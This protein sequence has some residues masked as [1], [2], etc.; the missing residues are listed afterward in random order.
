[1]V[2]IESLSHKLRNKAK[3]SALITSIQHC[4]GSVTGITQR[5]EINGIYIDRSTLVFI[6]YEMIIYIE[7]SMKST[8]RLLELISECKLLI[9]INFNET[10]RQPERKLSCPATVVEPSNKISSSSI[11]ASTQPMKDHGLCFL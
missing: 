4:I 9:N 7:N 6:G 3:M 10:V 2:K 1:M 5:K 8:K 11:L